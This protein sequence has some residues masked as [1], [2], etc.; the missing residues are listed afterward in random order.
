MPLPLIPIVII[1]TSAAAAL[2]GA[3]DTVTGVSQITEEKRRYQRHRANYE[4]AEQQYHNERAMVEHQLEALGQQRIEAMQTLRHV[5]NFI[6]RVRIS[7]QPILDRMHVTR[8]ELEHWEGLPIAATDVTRGIAGSAGAG[9]VTMYGVYAAVGALGTASTGTAIG[10]LSGAAATNATLAWFGGG[11]LAAGGGGMALGT[12][13][14]GG[15]V[16][17]PAVLVSGFFVAAHAE[18]VKTHVQQQIAH[19]DVA[20]AEM[21]QQIGAF[22]AIKARANELASS[23]KRLAE[24]VE[25]GLQTADIASEDEVYHVLRSAKTLAELIKISVLE[26]SPVA[27]NAGGTG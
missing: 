6:R 10:T 24:Q 26:P 9:L 2:K 4:E 5:A 20:Q 19:L 7:T 16:V 17:G 14:L 11:S 18:R 8:D 27:N 12:A 23:I 1:G 21:S 25:R 13:V 3:L 22:V 15:V